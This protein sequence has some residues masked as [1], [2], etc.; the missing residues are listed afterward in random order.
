MH[1]NSLPKGEQC[2]YILMNWYGV[3]LNAD[4]SKLQGMVYPTN[5]SR[6]PCSSFIIL[7]GIIPTSIT[8]FFN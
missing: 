3:L 4:G 1:H 5:T 6:G 7:Y 2:I 8:G